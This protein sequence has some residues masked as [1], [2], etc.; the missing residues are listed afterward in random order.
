[1]LE[2]KIEKFQQDL[3]FKRLRLFHQS[4]INLLKGTENPDML[5]GE[6]FD[7]SVMDITDVTKSN[8][9]Y[10]QNLYLQK[11]HLALI[12]NLR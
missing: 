8:E 4:I 2:L 11:L 10:F 5:N 3:T 7:E 9:I 1:M 6:I 12:F